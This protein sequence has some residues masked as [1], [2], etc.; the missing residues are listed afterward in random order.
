MRHGND[1]ANPKPLLLPPKHR[2]LV[3]RVGPSKATPSFISAC[4]AFWLLPGQIE[5]PSAG[6]GGKQPAAVKMPGRLLRTLD[7]MHSAGLG[8]DA[9]ELV[10]LFGAQTAV[11]TLWGALAIG[12]L[13]R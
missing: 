5:Q 9:S 8:S 2:A 6:Q 11:L 12:I 7:G 10:E 1:F 3:N 4:P 13:P